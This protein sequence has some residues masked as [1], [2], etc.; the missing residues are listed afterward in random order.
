[1]V[2]PTLNIKT[3]VA[4]FSTDLNGEL[5][6]VR[7]KD[8]YRWF[9]F[10]GDV[11]QA[12]I[13]TLNREN[14]LL[15]VPQSMLLFLLWKKGPLNVLNLGMGAGS[16]E[17]AL[18]KFP[19]IQVTSVEAESQIIEMA[20]RYF[21]SSENPYI[22]H[23]N[24][25]AFI[26]TTTDR[27]HLILCDI[28][29]QEQSP[30]CVYSSGFYHDL[31]EKLSESGII[32]INLFPENKENLLRIMAVSRQFFDHAALIEFNYY[33]NIVLI[34]GKV[35]LPTKEQLIS[36]NDLPDKLSNI[37]FKEHINN[38]HFVPLRTI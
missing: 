13:D 17:N 21:L 30:D 16:I 27:Y 22:F 11:V 34:L 19:D 7:E 2:R 12:A 6:E 24:A 33:Q 5:L 23:Q 29:Y 9:H 20:K 38:I 4:L 15:P 28:F 1:V 32:F 36:L 37:N 31:N 10:G 14:I 35:A 3:G 18:E 8:N 25:E 26:Q